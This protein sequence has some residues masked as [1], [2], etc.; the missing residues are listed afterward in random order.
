[1]S[2]RRNVCALTTEIPC[3]WPRISPESG[4]TV[5]LILFYCFR[6]CFRMKDKGNENAM[7]LIWTQTLF[8]EHFLLEKKKT[9]F[10]WNLIL[11]QLVSKRTQ[12]ITTINQEN[13]NS[14]TFYIGNPKTTTLITSLVW[15]YPVVEAQT[16]LLRTFHGARK[17][18]EEK[19]FF[20][21][22]D[23]KRN[24]PFLNCFK[25]LIQSETKCKGH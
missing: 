19:A 11:L 23:C 4:D 22:A 16:S 8:V 12:K 17:E 9:N 1:M 6:Y 13:K 24:R 14:S 5:I 18:R 10:S 3:W 21:S 25:P 20:E 7:N 15:S 2:R